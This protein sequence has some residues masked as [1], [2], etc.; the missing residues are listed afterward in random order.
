MRIC[1]CPTYPYKEHACN[2]DHNHEK[3]DHEEHK[4]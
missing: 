2:C 4:D 3:D 1:K